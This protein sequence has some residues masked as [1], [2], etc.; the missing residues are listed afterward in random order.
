MVGDFIC[1]FPFQDT[2]IVCRLSEK[3]ES[4]C[5]IIGFGAELFSH[6]TDILS[7]LLEPDNAMRL[8]LLEE[9]ELA[10][11][12]ATATHAVHFDVCLDIL[13]N[14]YPKDSV[15]PE[16][17]PIDVEHTTCEPIIVQVDSRNGDHNE[18]IA[19]LDPS[20]PWAGA[21]SHSRYAVTGRDIQNSQ[22]NQSL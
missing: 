2:L 13:A 5:R 7:I 15:L 8:A 21:Q 20:G 9:R 12:R 4:K 10:F 6:R 16:W 3:D 18:F 14:L 11:R 1:N 19:R 22:R 17:I